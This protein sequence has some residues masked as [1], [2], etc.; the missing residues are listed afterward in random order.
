[1]NYIIIGNSF[2]AVNAIE[3]IRSIDKEGNIN[4]ISKENHPAY[5]RPLISYVLQGKSKKENIYQ[6]SEDFYDKNKVNVFYNVSAT[7]FDKETVTLSSG[8]S[9]P[10]DKLL[11]ACGSHPFVPPMK[12]LDGVK[13]KHSFMT[14]DDL[15]E[16]EEAVKVTDRVLIFGAGLIGLKA[17]E[18]IKDRCA[19]LDIVDLAPRV[20]PSILDESTAKE[21]QT[22]LEANGLVFHLGVTAD[23]F[24]KNSVK[25]TDGSVLNFDLLI[26]AVGVKAEIGLAKEAGCLVN[27]GVLVDERCQTSLENVY[28]AGDCA[29]GIEAVSGEHRVLAIIPTASMQGHA[30]GVNMAG[31]NELSAPTI[32]MNSI[33]FFGTHM[34]TAGITSG[35]E[36]RVELEE[37]GARR[38]F[39]KDDRLVGF[40]LTGSGIERAGIYTNLVRNCVPLSSIDWP[41]LKETPLLAAFALTER[42]AMLSKEV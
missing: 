33:G 24:N 10:Y 29:E 41:L 26:L 5:C 30:A 38:F 9:L 28:A 1:M 17:A 21:V 20:L 13:N 16:V 3:G 23:E 42:K 40:I 12:G 11:L 32:A 8:I 2:A 6:K 7:S 37:G 18:G 35:E 31:G 36:E 4:V 34:I 25:L 14:I 27:R 15:E 22:G 19:S 39:V